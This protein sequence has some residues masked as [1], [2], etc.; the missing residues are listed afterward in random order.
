MSVSEFFDLFLKELE[1]SPKL[2]YYYKYHQDPQKLLFRKAY[3]CQRLQYI[4]DNVNNNPGKIWDCGCGFGTTGI[5]LALNGIESYGTTLEHYMAEIPAR[6]AFYKSYGNVN[7]FHYDYAD[8]F[9]QAPK[10]ESFDTVIIQDTLHHLEPIDSAL[11]ILNQSL[12]KKGKLIAVEENGDNV[13]QRLKLYKQRGNK[14]IIEIY[15]EQLGRNILL[16]NE[17]IRGLSSW[18]KLFEKQGFV[19]DQ[20]SIHYVRYYLLKQFTTD[21]YDS[22]L[23]NEQKL[24]KKSPL[25]R[26]YFFFGLNFIAHKK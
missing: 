14:R 11:K 20:K 10:P 7:L 16:G 5:F 2:Q 19:I 8:L 9:T 17:N 22:I 23:V 6:V 12:T 3:F 21:N 1:Q 15:D 26:K 18:K 25:K 24:W 4:Y 13:I